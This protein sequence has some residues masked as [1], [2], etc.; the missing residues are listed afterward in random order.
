MRIYVH[1]CRFCKT[2]STTVKLVRYG[3]RHWAHDDCYLKAGKPLEALP[4]S[5]MGQFRVSVLHQFNVYQVVT[6]RWNAF[7]KSRRLPA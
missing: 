1:T 4:D 2:Q 3:T 7:N 6:D 5:Q